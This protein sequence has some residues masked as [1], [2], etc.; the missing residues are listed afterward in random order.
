MDIKL[1]LTIHAYELED[2]VTDWKFA[3][4]LKNEIRKETG[5]NIIVHR[6]IIKSSTFRYVNY[7]QFFSI[8]TWG[9]CSNHKSV[10]NPFKSKRFYYSSDQN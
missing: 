2:I 5:L 8:S 3:E 6:P 10:F 4:T 9:I 1:Q 7:Y